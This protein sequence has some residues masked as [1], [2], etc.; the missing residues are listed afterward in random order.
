MVLQGALCTSFYLLGLLLVTQ[1]WGPLHPHP[2]A[3][4]TRGVIPGWRTGSSLLSPP[5]GGWR[6]VHGPWHRC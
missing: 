6:A 2:A 5:H 1:V 3:P 4:S